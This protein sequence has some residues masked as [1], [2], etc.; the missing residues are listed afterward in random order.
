MSVTAM[1]RQLPDASASSLCSADRACQLQLFALLADEERLCH[2]RVCD[3]EDSSPSLQLR[4][5]FPRAAQDDVR[6]FN[7]DVELVAA[8]IIDDGVA[9][10]PMYLLCFAVPPHG[11]VIVSRLTIND[12]PAFFDEGAAV[13]SDF[14]LFFAISNYSPIFVHPDDGPPPSQSIRDGTNLRG[15]KRAFDSG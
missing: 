13:R 1:F 10:Y 2:R 9:P 4:S 14:P 15:N 8:F 3:C 12:R 7:R 6:A 5:E 11:G